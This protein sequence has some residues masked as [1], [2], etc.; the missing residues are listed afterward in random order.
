[1]LEYASF[2][3]EKRPNQLMRETVVYQWTAAIINL[4]QTQV[5]QIGIQSMKRKYVNTNEEMEDPE[6]DR[7]S[8]EDITGENEEN[9]T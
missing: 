8:S 6:G 4:K 7:R 3:T 2:L 5:M 1:M 9:N